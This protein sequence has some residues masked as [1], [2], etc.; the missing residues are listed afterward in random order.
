MTWRW[1]V[2]MLALG[3]VWVALGLAAFAVYSSAGESP[4]FWWLGLGGVVLFWIGLAEIGGGLVW[5]GL[6]GVHAWRRWRRA[7]AWE[8][9]WRNGG[10]G[11]SW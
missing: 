10:D 6:H 2:I 5:F 3:T 7:R 8:D 1:P 4:L 9:G 11:T